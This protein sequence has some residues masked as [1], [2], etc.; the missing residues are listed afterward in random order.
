MK[1]F[2][3]YSMEEEKVMEL[4]ATH[5]IM[6]GQS[7]DAVNQSRNVLVKHQQVIKMKSDFQDFL[8]TL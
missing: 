5:R 2:N 8:D 4:F 1:K 3:A 7:V 6:E